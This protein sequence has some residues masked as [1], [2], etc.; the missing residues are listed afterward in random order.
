MTAP[1]FSS[2]RALIFDL[3]GTLIDSHRDLIRSVHAMLHEMGRE[4][5]HEESLT[6]AHRTLPLGTVVEVTNGQ[7]GRKAVFRINDR[8]PFVRRRLSI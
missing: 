5:L 4:Q 6:A 3:D 1:N 8:G 2:V 7:N